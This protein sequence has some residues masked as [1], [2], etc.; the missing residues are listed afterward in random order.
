MRILHLPWLIGRKIWPLA[1]M[2]AALTAAV[3]AG[4][5]TADHPLDALSWDEYW[6]VLDALADTLGQLDRCGDLSDVLE[7]RAA[8][9]TDDAPARARAS[10]VLPVPGGPIS[11]RL[12]PPAAA[13]S[14]ARLAWC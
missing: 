3:P 14:S 11:S 7:R 10:M 13:I 6:I 4:G 9:A 5:Q 1:L 2:A 8:V 12:W